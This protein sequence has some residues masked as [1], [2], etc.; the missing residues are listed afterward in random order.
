MTQKSHN[1]DGNDAVTCTA[2]HSCLQHGCGGHI[3]PCSPTTHLPLREGVYSPADCPR[4]PAQLLRLKSWFLPGAKD[5]PR[6]PSL[7]VRLSSLWVSSEGTCVQQGR[8]QGTRCPMASVAAVLSSLLKDRA[9]H[10]PVVT[11]QPPERCHHLVRQAS[12]CDSTA[13]W[14]CHP[15]QMEDS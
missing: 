15:V 11:I 12:P 14:W 10:A 7:T 5:V 3:L 1:P 2:L 4:E 6:S 13:S 8:A 9:N